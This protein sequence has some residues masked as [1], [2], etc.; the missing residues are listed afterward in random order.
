MALHHDCYINGD[1]FFSGRIYQ[2]KKKTK[3]TSE[4]VV[5]SYR[6]LSH[7]KDPPWSAVKLFPIN[8]VGTIRLPPC[9]DWLLNLRLMTRLPCPSDCKPSTERELDR[10]TCRGESD[11]FRWSSSFG[12]ETFESCDR[13][14]TTLNEKERISVYLF[15]CISKTCFMCHN[16]KDDKDSLLRKLKWPILPMGF[17]VFLFTR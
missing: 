14:L 3:T 8:R 16:H 13:F 10:N 2:K 1:M 7:Y 4:K 15:F 6:Y 17:R 5:C 12:G 9:R 11:C